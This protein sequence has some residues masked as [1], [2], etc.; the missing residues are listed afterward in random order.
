[1]GSLIGEEMRCTA[2]IK[3]LVREID[4]V[5]HKAIRFA[6]PITQLQLCHCVML[7]SIGI[8]EPAWANP[9]FR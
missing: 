4:D 7:D 8:F 9:V 3:A 5:M 1:M 2:A 6:A